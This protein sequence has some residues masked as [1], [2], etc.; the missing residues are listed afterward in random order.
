MLGK[1]EGKRRRG[2][3]RIS[4]LDGITNSMDMSLSKPQDMVKDREA[5]HTTIHGVAK[6]WTWLSNWTTTGE[7]LRWEPLVYRSRGGTKVVFFLFVSSIYLIETVLGLGCRASQVQWKRIHL[8]VQEM[9]V[10]SLDWEDPL[11]QEMATR[12]SILAMD[13][14]AWW[15]TVCGVAE[16]D[17]TELAHKVGVGLGGAVLV[18]A[19]ELFY[20]CCDLWDPAW[21]LLGAA[22]RI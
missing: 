2:W 21:E 20:L 16:S 13:R 6:S 8:P 15:A 1:I 18:A 3:Q 11:E 12:F 19:H 22:C 17:M 7:Y 10:Q 14:R 9:Q 4:W 5:W